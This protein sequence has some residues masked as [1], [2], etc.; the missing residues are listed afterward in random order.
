MRD[1][2]CQKNNFP[3]NNPPQI[4]NVGLVKCGNVKNILVGFFH[5]KDNL[6]SSSLQKKLSMHL[7]STI[8]ILFAEHK[9]SLGQVRM[10]QTIWEVSSMVFSH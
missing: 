9:L 6:C 4:S 8:D 3:S 5:V 7:K 1:K 10:V 2:A